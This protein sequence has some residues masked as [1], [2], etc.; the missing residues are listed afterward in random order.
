MKW[1]KNT[2]WLFTKIYQK[3]YHED[4]Q[5]STNERSY[6]YHK[7][8]Y[9]WYKVALQAKS[10]CSYYLNSLFRLKTFWKFEYEKRKDSLPLRP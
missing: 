4:G 3:S 2:P 1:K 6:R 9:V 7:A 10:M 5:E 8:S